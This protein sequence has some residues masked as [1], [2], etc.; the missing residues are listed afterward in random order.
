LHDHAPS[1]T[2]I[3]AII[4]L[5]RCQLRGDC[6]QQPHEM[7]DVFSA[8]LEKSNGDV[9]LMAAYSDFALQTLGDAELAERMSR[10]VVAAK[11]QVP[12]F[13]EN[14]IRLL[15]ATR[16]CDAADTAI[17]ELA[18]LNYAGSLDSTIAA[19]KAATEAARAAPPA[20]PQNP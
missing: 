13:R 10:A 4:F 6:P 1:Q 12:V 2:D 7:L 15:V 11:P 8:A 9:N 3:D 16:Q 20:F 17:R 19:L 14:L 5:F 18:T